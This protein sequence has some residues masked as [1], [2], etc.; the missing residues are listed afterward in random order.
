MFPTMMI[1][2]SPSEIVS[3]LQIKGFLL[4]SALVIV[5]LQSNRAVTNTATLSFSWKR[6]IIPTLD[7][8]GP[9]LPIRE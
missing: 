1:M 8:I 4:S 2:D 6:Y 9:S 7:E 5:P 3:E